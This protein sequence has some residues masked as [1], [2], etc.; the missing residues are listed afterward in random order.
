[1]TTRQQARMP[2][3]LAVLVAAAALGTASACSQPAETNTAPTDKL[4]V[5]SWW[6]SASESAALNVLFTDY[7]KAH[8]GVTVQNDAVVGGGGSNVQVVLASRLRANEPPDVWQ[9]FLGT[10]LREYVKRGLVNDLSSVYA[11]DNLASTF[12]KKILDAV[13]VDGKQWGVPTG[14][15]RSN[16]LFYNA[17]LLARAGVAAPAGGYNIKTL[18]ADLARLKS[19]G[20][21]PLCLG[22]KDTFASAELFENTLLGVVGP[23]GWG[24]ITADKFAW[25]GPEAKKALT[26]FGQLL[27]YADPASGGLTWNQATKKLAEGKCAFE[28]FNDSAYGELVTDGSTEGT[29]FGAV[30][31][32]GTDAS[33]LA[34]VDTFVSGKGAKNGKNALDF[35][36]VLGSAETEAGFNK[37]KGSVPLRSDVDLSAMSPY[38]QSAAKSLREGTVLLSI[39]HGEAMSPSFQQGFYDAVSAY[40]KGRDVQAFANTLADAV[41]TAA[42]LPA[43]H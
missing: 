25:T 27:D 11:A 21:T 35:L 24:K 18:I 10:S 2:R 8:A 36:T 28:S 37:V 9:T 17:K 15:H 5:V 7:K 29:D 26:Q 3:A 22:G 43:P 33:Y 19:A 13:T 12:P 1:M 14:S 39:V 31:F 4:E 41:N 38:Q 16:V 30:P 6:T 42:Q 40:V 23:A 32:P 20:V 34:V